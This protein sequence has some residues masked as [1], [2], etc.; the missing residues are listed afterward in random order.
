MPVPY[1]PVELVKL[2]VA[3][4]ALRKVDL[5]SLNLTARV[6]PPLVRP[7]LF[8]RLDIPLEWIS[9]DSE[10]EDTSAF[11]RA[12]TLRELDRLTSF[13]QR[14]DLAGLVREVCVYSLWR[15]NVD[16]GSPP[17]SLRISAYDLMQL[18]YTVFPRLEEASSFLADPPVA[19]PRLPVPC[20]HTLH[21]LRGLV[22]D[23]HT[24]MSLQTCEA[25][26]VLRIE[27]ISFRGEI[28][29][30]PPSLPFRLETIEIGLMFERKHG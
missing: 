18:V 27:E 8:R 29:A 21:T 20:C 4:P 15:A 10:P 19:P 7:H 30:V 12:I 6:F 3:D 17:V 2:I 25:L 11:N 1:L 14:P 26:R 16:L 9:E 23:S 22:L 13:R 5:Q 24:W 28:P